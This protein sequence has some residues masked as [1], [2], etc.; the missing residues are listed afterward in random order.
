[1]LEIPSLAAMLVMLVILDGGEESYEDDG[2]S[3]WER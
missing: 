3:E 1:M 2:M